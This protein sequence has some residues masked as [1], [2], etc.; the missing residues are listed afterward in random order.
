MFRPLF[1]NNPLP[2]WCLIETL[3]FPGSETPP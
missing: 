1:S 3:R 2:T